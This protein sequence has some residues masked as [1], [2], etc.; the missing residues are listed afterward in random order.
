MM[1]VD[2]PRPVPPGGREVLEIGWSFPFGPISNRMGVEQIDGSYVYEVAQWYPRLA[3]YDDVRGWNTEQYLGQGEFYL[4]YGSFDV[5]LTVPSQHVGC[6]HRHAAEPGRGADR[7]SAQ[8]A[9][10]SPLQ[11]LDGGHPGQG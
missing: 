7:S 9:Q 3:V 6:R 1:R 2:L 10:P 11:R 4:E 5:S 8:P